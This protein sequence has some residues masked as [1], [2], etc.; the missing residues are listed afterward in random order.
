MAEPTAVRSD[1]SRSTRHFWSRKSLSRL[2]SSRT[3]NH[4]II[5]VPL[6]AIAGEIESQNGCITA[7]PAAAATAAIA[8]HAHPGD[9]PSPPQSEQAIHEAPTNSQ[10]LPNDGHVVSQSTPQWAGDDEATQ[11]GAEAHPLEG[12]HP[13]REDKG[14]A[15]A[16]A[17]DDAG[18]SASNVPISANNAT[19]QCGM[20][21]PAIQA[22]PIEIPYN[23]TSTESLSKVEGLYMDKTAVIAEA[24]GE[25]WKNEIQGKLDKDLQHL[26]RAKFGVKD[27]IPLSTQLCMVGRLLKHKETL[28]VQPTIIITCGTMESKKWIAEELG[29]LKLYYLDDF[30][31]PWRVQYKRKPP[32]WNTRAR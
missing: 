30:S 8:N 12:T 14:K 9:E 24:I 23:K 1:E 2:L 4:Q 26:V 25:R 17:M 16:H 21:V 32:S 31:C 13:R 19:A 3:P 5:E 7:P 10:H 22:Y 6:L 18:S 28:A 29:N 27:N 15:K 11:N 20:N